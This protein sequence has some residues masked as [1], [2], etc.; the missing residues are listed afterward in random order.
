MT[1]QIQNGVLLLFYFGELGVINLNPV[2]FNDTLTKLINWDKAR[3]SQLF[4]C[5]DAFFSSHTCVLH[6]L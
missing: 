5:F 3:I 1:I 2:Q 6:V 4:C